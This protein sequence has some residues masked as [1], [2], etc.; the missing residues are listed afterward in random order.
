[1]LQ[2]LTNNPAA[3]N[4][5]GLMLVLIGDGTGMTPD[6]VCCPTC[7]AAVIVLLN[8]LAGQARTLNGSHSSNRT[9]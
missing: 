2:K 8:L 4:L 6:L 1:M 9:A 7:G 3:L 5:A